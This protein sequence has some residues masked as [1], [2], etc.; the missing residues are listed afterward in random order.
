MKP[1]FYPD[2]PPPGIY[3]DDMNKHLQV[4]WCNIRNDIVRDQD[5]INRCLSQIKA[6]KREIK[7]FKERI[8]AQKNALHVL[9][10]VKES[11][12]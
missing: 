8:V 5:G 7:F 11:S 6:V 10:Q 2:P 9:E 12:K 4:T 3:P 1:Q